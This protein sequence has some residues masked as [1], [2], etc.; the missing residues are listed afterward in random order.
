MK[1]GDTILVT[2]PM[3]VTYD[4]SGG[5]IH[6]TFI[7]CIANIVVDDVKVGEVCGA[8]GGRVDVV[9]ESERV[10]LAVEPA[11]LWR[12]VMRALGRDENGK[13]HADNPDGAGPPAGGG[14][15]RP[16]APGGLPD[17]A[18]P[19]ALAAQAADGGRDDT[20]ADPVARH[21]DSDAAPPAADSRGA[22][23]GQPSDEEGLG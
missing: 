18:R 22:K 10:H 23:A 17:G 14:A 8:I 3:M 9:L 20:D 21:A 15:E 5:T 6:V 2:V 4:A 13:E 12:A 1:R 7:D 16:E 11:E 19:G